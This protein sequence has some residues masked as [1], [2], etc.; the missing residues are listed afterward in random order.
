M[1]T[2]KSFRPLTGLSI[3]NRV[4]KQKEVWRFILSFRP[5]TGLSISNLTWRRLDH[6]ASSFPFPSP[7]G[8]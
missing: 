1:H 7:Y 8:A 6:N 4:E 2:L 5:L 3:S